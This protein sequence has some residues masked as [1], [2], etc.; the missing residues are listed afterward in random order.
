MSQRQ[1]WNVRIEINQ[2]IDPVSTQKTKTFIKIQPPAS[3][4][5]NMSLK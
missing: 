3:Q 5:I 2:L 1:N 4:K